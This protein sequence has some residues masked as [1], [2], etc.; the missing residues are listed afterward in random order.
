MAYMLVVGA[1]KEK[2][3]VMDDPVL[4]VSGRVVYQEDPSEENRASPFVDVMRIVVDCVAVMVAPVA[5]VSFTW[6]GSDFL[7]VPTMDDP[8]L[9]KRRF[10]YVGDGD[11]FSSV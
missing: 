1:L 8:V 3:G 4:M 5:L 6:S 10:P 2:E 7:S 9:T 11:G